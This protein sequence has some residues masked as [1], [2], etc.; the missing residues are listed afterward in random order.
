M[1]SRDQI[2]DSA[3]HGPD[4]VQRK[5]MGS[6]LSRSASVRGIERI[7]AR[8][9]TPILWVVLAIVSIIPTASFLTLAISPRLFDQG[10][11][12][13]SSLAFRQAF[14]GIELQGIRNSL[15][16][17]TGASLLAVTLASLL[18]LISQRTDLTIAR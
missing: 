4:A 6:G 16:I 17:A 10:P 7:L 11:S 8:S 13:L 1:R 15:L 12:W 2:D 18:A 3:E 9:A 5:W 14:S